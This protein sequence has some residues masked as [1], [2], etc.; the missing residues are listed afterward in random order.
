MDDRHRHRLEE[1]REQYPMG[2]AV[3]LV[4]MDDDQ[5]PPKGTRGVVLHVDILGTVHILW[6]TGS[7]LGIVAPVDEVCIV[8]NGMHGRADD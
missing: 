5:A 6:E 1:L 2:V 3:E 8:E 4:S 7:T